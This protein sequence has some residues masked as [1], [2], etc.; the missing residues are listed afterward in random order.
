MNKP[1][2]SI[3]MGVYNGSK[4]VER[5]IDSI[6]NQ[7]YKDWEFI[8]CDDCSSDN[9]LDILEKYQKKDIRIKV[10]KNEKNLGLAATLNKCIEK[11]QGVYIARQDDD[12]ISDYSRLEKE[13]NFLK[14]NKEYSLVG[15]N[16]YLIDENEVIWGEW[17]NVE[18]PTKLD[19]IKGVCFIHPTVVIKKEVIT[20]LGCYD[21]N[22]LRVEDYDLWFKLYSKNYKGYNIQE[23]LL[24]Y[25][26]NVNSYKKRKYIYRVNEFKVRLRGYHINKISYKHYLYAIKPLVIGLIPV[27]WISKFHKSK[28]NYN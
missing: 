28:F 11:S 27:S 20:N 21:K 3:I 6:I 10:F 15:S 1:E 4:Y 16:A 22:A 8:I 12:D 26:L 24:T 25:S 17:S 18:K 5:A 23:N 2:T 19:L 9:T 13:V 14:E 7:T